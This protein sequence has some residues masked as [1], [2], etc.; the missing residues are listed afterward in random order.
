[1]ATHPDLCKI[2]RNE[3]SAPRYVLNAL[4]RPFQLT[5]G[6]WL[7]VSTQVFGFRSGREFPKMAL[8]A[9]VNEVYLMKGYI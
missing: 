5:G 2:F 7:A 6:R 1:M 3:E 9:T 4:E 8:S